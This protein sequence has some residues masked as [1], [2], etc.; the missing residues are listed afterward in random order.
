MTRRVSGSFTECIIVH[1]DVIITGLFVLLSYTQNG[2]TLNL[3][4]TSTGLPPTTITWSKDEVEMSSG[5]SHAIS[6]RAIDVENTV[7]ES[8][9]IISVVS[10]CDMQGLYHCSVQCHD[11]TGD[12]VDSA[13]DS[14]NVSG[15][16]VCV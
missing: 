2:L 14:V 7:F 12:I 6:Q 8:V 9:L 15:E 11:D 16:S 13:N 10:V 5:G 3:N 1:P 4:C